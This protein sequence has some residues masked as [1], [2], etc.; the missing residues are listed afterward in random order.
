M[1]QDDGLTVWALAT[2]HTVAFVLVVL[3]LGYRGGGL[4]GALGSLNTGIGFAAFGGLWLITRYTTRRAVAASKLGSG[5]AAFV[6]CALRWGAITAWSF[7][8]LFVLAA[9]VAAP[10][11][12][13]GNGV[14]NLSLF[15]F[16][17]IGSPLALIIGALVG[18][19]LGAIDSVAASVA[20]AIVSRCSG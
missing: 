12:V 1:N 9:L 11:A 17:V 7:L 8:L 18:A 5:P 14:P 20:D 4:A 13:P 6:P 19:V 2:F 10:F 3:F 15:A 16:G